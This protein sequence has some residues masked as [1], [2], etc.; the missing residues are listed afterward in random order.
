METEAVNARLRTYK[1]L[2]GIILL[3]LPCYCAGFLALTWRVP[4]RNV[5]STPTLMA[6]VTNPALPSVTAGILTLLPSFT[7]GPPTKPLEATPTQFAPPSRTPSYTPTVTETPT[8]TATPTITTT[9]TP[10]PSVTSTPVPTLTDTP[11]ATLVPPSPTATTTPE[12]PTFTPTA[13]LP[14]PALTDTPTPTVTA[15]P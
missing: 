2:V 6:T 4:D 7:A 5:T 15:G 9:P 12:P 13:T 10:T 8:T 1:I 11:T 14:A 3:T